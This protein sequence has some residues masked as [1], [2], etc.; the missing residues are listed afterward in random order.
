MTARTS[1]RR[2]V[3]DPPFPLGLKVPNVQTHVAMESYT[4][5]ADD[6]PAHLASNNALIDDLEKNTGQ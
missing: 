3:I 6:C 1:M 5:M 4:M 2:V